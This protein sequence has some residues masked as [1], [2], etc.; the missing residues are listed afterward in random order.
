MPKPKNVKNALET[1]FFSDTS[2][3]SLGD[4]Y[5]KKG[6]L[7]ANYVIMRPFCF[8]TKSELYFRFLNAL[9]LLAG[10]ALPFCEIETFVL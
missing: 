7:S 6:Q 2:F 9:H 3:V 8:P 10:N 4:P 1:G 5:E